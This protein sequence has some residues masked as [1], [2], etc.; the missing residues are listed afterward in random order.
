[1][2]RREIARAQRIIEGQN[3]ELRRT[4]ARYAATLEAQYELV[5]ERRA[6][7]LAT[8]R[9]FGPQREKAG[10]LDEDLRCRA[11]VRRPTGR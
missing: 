1:M 4:L 7:R 10:R 11:E 8:Q 2:V 9:R 5:M 3:F 6:G